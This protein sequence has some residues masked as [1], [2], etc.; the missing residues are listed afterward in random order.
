MKSRRMRWTGYVAHME[1]KRNL[2]RILAGNL[3]GTRPPWRPK[4]KLEKNTE[5]N[6]KV[7]RWEGVDWIPLA[8]DGPVAGSREHGNGSSSSINFWEILV[9][10]KTS[11]SLSISTPFRL[12]S[13]LYYF[14]YLAR[15]AQSVTWLCPRQEKEV[16]S[17][18]QRQ[19][20]LWGP[21]QSPTQGVP[22]ARS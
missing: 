21:T 14:P 10:L 19:D 3:E 18:P 8:E 7:I 5:T 1:E 20:R 4:F 15:L 2:Y 13:R 22:G 6:L 11:F 12:I 17:S 9:Q 16:L